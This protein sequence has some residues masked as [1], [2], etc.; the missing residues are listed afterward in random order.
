MGKTELTKALSGYS[1]DDDEIEDALR[2]LELVQQD[3][4]SIGLVEN[5]FVDLLRQYIEYSP[6]PD[7]DAALAVHYAS[8]ADP[9]LMRLREQYDLGAIAGQGTE[10]DRLRNLMHWVHG[11][12][13]HTSNAV[14]PE[15]MNSLNLLNLIRTEG[16]R[17]NCWMFATIL[18]DAYL[19]L[20]WKSRIVHLKPYRKG[21]IESHVVNAVY[22]EQLAKWL[23]FDP[24]L[25]AYFMDE[26]GGMLSPAEIRQ[27]LI[28]GAALEVNDELAFNSDNRVFA[29][30]GQH[31]G[32][33]FYR[34]YIAKN[35]FRYD[36]RQFSTFD[37]ESRLDGR[38][39]IELLPV[40]YR[41]ELL[42]RP[43][44]TAKCDRTIYTT[45]LTQ[46]WQ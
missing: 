41:T 1:L 34:L 2:M 13:I 4:S 12:A 7:P 40:G 9:N 20:G 46:F 26:W 22:C 15:R 19:A 31:F 28:E 6:D 37:Y 45:N 8:P 24:A 30:L 25:S 23:F 43:Q 27:R 42:A 36:C 32:G 18:N 17:I 44:V 38:V 29:A 21:H 11:L 39:Y 10:I 16:K 33:E 5:R 3:I 14:V 35:I